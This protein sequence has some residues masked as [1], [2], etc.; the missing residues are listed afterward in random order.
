LQKF[1]SPFPP[2]TLSPPDGKEECPLT[3]S[4]C[5][6]PTYGLRFFNAP[7]QVTDLYRRDYLESS[8]WRKTD[9]VWARKFHEGKR[10]MM[11][12]VGSVTAS[13]ARHGMHL[14]DDIG[15]LDGTSSAD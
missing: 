8:A 6:A 7:S 5:P 4:L 14:A 3:W 10:L 9:A 13:I 1:T 15:R 12:I 2:S 11:F